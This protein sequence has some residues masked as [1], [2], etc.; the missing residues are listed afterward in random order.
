[1]Q[2]AYC[3]LGHHRQCRQAQTARRRA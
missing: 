2:H 3:S 1:V